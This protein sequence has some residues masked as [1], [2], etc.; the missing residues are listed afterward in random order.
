MGW[1]IEYG[2]VWLIVAGALV[3]GIIAWGIRSERRQG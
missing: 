2:V 3:L 1:G